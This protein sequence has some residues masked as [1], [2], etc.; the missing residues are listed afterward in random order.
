M[1]G[2]K[3][4]MTR[5]SFAPACKNEDESSTITMNGTFMHKSDTNFYV[6]T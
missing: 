5:P 6:Y 3:S 4:E 1:Q 2:F